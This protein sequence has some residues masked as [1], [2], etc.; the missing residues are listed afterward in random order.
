MEAVG[1]VHRVVVRAAA[2]DRQTAA[3]AATG[4]T[5]LGRQELPQERAWRARVVQTK[6]LTVA[7][8]LVVVV[9]ERA[10][11]LA[12]PVVRQGSQV[13]GGLLGSLRAQSLAGAA[14]TRTRGL[15]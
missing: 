5:H 13:M 1:A 10:V 6:G 12:V 14:L 2:R 11:L 4:P 9:L 7:V 15:W 8:V 3:A